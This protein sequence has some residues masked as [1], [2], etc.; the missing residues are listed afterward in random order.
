MPIPMFLFVIPSYPHLSGTAIHYCFILRASPIARVLPCLGFPAAI[1]G[2]PQTDNKEHLGRGLWV[3]GD[4]CPYRVHP[5]QGPKSGLNM[6]ALI[7]SP[8]ILHG[9]SSG[10][11]SSAI[12][13]SQERLS[14]KVPNT[15]A[16]RNKCLT[17]GW[18]GRT[19]PAGMHHLLTYWC[20][21]SSIH[22]KGSFQ[23]IQGG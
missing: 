6:V 19:R 21:M 14:P 8:N 13:A 12:L 9:R 7:R 3:F 22:S 15:P 18:R 11:S 4:C 5:S 1:T 20:R 23:L 16:S 2:L 17:P 10:S